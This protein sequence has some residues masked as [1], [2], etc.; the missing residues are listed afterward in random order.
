MG[1]WEIG[2]IGG[3][4]CKSYRESP[5]KNKTEGESGGGEGHNR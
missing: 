5:C 3:S 1:G 2:G 4:A